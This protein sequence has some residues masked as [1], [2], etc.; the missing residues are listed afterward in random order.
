MLF[1]MSTKKNKY[2]WLALLANKYRGVENTSKRFN[3]FMQAG[4]LIVFKYGVILEIIVRK[5]LY[6]DSSRR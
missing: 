3:S 4:K 5:Q 2:W 1:N 6:K